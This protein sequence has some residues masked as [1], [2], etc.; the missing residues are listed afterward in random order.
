LCIASGS[1]SV[2]RV[3]KSVNSPSEVSFCHALKYTTS[4]D[5][6]VQNSQGLRLDI[7]SNDANIAIPAEEEVSIFLAKWLKAH[8][9]TGRLS[10]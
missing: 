7:R 1:G 9:G 8:V 5:T 2:E 10:V 4:P 3:S 6:P